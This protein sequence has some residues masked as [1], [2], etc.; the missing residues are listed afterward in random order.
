MYVPT[1]III[2]IGIDE[3]GKIITIEI[4]ETILIREK[5]VHKEVVVKNNLDSELVRKKEGQ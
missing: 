5:K 3:E 4:I 1:I 2:I